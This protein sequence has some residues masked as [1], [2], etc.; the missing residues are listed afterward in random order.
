MSEDREKI[1]ARLRELRE[2]LR[3]LVESNDG[4]GRAEVIQQHIKKLQEEL[5]RA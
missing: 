1:E 2:E 5:A 4:A 3:A